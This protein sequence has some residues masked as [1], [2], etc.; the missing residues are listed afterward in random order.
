M[1][2][3][4]RKEEN[5]EGKKNQRVRGEEKYAA[6]IYRRLRDERATQ[7]KKRE[8]E[9]TRKFKRTEMERKTRR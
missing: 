5:A 8:I 6:E 4:G 7:E 1:K 9:T 2:E 3:E